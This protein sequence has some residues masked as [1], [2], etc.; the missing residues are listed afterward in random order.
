M[1]HDCKLTFPALK[2]KRFPFKNAHQNQQCDFSEVFLLS[3]DESVVQCC[4][5]D[6]KTIYKWKE[7]N[8]SCLEG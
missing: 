4:L 7:F 5:G 8:I 3:K 1:V 6:Q 2:M